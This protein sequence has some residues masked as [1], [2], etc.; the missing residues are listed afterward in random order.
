M[1]RIKHKFKLGDRV[2]V[3]DRIIRVRFPPCFDFT[4]EIVKVGVEKTEEG[5]LFP[6]YEVKFKDLPFSHFM[7]EEWVDIVELI[8]KR[9]KNIVDENIPI[10]TD[11]WDRAKLYP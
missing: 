1:E 9:L 7:R 4:C 3:T 5:A 8:A 11:K 10:R 6:A 2:V